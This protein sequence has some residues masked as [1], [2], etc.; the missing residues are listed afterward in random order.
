M[1]V[2]LNLFL[3]LPLRMLQVGGR[4]A[5]IVPDGVLFSASTAHKSIRKEL[6]ENHRLQAVVS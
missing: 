4:C 6:I 3:K 2:F 1:V 5:C